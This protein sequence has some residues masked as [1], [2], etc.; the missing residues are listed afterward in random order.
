MPTVLQA[1]ISSVPAGAVTFL[2]STVMFTSAIFVA[3]ASCRHFH[4][5]SAAKMAALLLRHYRYFM[6]CAM[7][8]KLTGLAIQVIFK[9]FSK[10]FHECHDRHGRRIAKRTESSAQH[11]LRK[12]I[13]IVD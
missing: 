6:A 1:S 4:L 11:V 13:H 10:L 3:P 2:P 12:V 8:F 7:L 9:F 5:N